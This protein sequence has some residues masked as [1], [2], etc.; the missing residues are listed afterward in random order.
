MSRTDELL[1]EF[2]Q[3][4]RATSGNKSSFICSAVS[5]SVFN[6]NSAETAALH[7][8]RKVSQRTTF[9]FERL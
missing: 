6:R 3:I 1:R 2:V 9:L 7:A 8:E 5:P 4:V